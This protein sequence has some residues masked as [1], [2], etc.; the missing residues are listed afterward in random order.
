LNRYLLDNPPE[1]I[2]TPEYCY[3]EEEKLPFE[4]KILALRKDH[5]AMR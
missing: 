4:K 2:L 5:K 1:K 3:P